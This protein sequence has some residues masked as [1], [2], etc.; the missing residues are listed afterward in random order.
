MVLLLAMVLSSCD[1]RQDDE[2]KSPSAP[3][4]PAASTSPAAESTP[5]LASQAAKPTGKLPAD[6]SCVTAQCHADLALAPQ[7]HGPVAAAILAWN[8]ATLRGT[9]ESS[10]TFSGRSQIAASSGQS[11]VTSESEVTSAP[12]AGG[13]SVCHQDD[14]GGHV[15]PLKRQGNA[16]C[17][18]CHTVT[19]RHEF[20]HAAVADPGC[21]ACH[22][23]HTSKAKFLLTADSVADVCLKCHTMADGLH[24][25]GPVA[26]GE[27]TN[28][29]LPHEA[30]VPR[31]LRG[32]QVPDHCFTCHREMQDQLTRATQKHEPAV[33]NCLACHTP[34]A[35]DEP[36]QLK[37]AVAPLCFSCHPAMGDKI[38][39]A[40]VP[41]AAVSTAEKCANCHDPHA[42]DQSF[43]LRDRT[44]RLCLTC[45]NQSLPTADG[46]L[47][48]DM[49]AKLVNRKFMHGPVAAGQCSPCHDVHG[50][51]YSRLL[52][53][54]FPQSFYAPFDIQEYALCFSCHSAAVVQE[55][56][57]TSLTNFRAGQRNL[58]YVHVHQQKK[59]R[60]CKTCHEIH[61]SDLPNHMADAVP[62]EGTQW[63]MPIQYQPSPDGG[64]CA[65]G[66]HEPKSY[67]RHS[68]DNAA[69][70]SSG[71]T[72]G[73]DTSGGDTSGGGASGGD[74]SGGNASG[75]GT[76]GGKEGTP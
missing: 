4:S 54:N 51:A 62:F 48:P 25:H 15:F 17:Q 47:V 9:P 1:R 44:D 42:A 18:F 37:Q 63:S 67:N 40:A 3:P 29:H 36:H 76:S 19:G 12:S 35:S 65:P 71:D 31:L 24:R 70:T 57:T 20:M 73:G 43:L 52:T 75:G 26:A 38:S 13:C 22:Q 56:I 49:T 45:H 21:L 30:D 53:K 6:A 41:H 55:P 34:H 28:C 32:G 16:L 74:T 69:E 10:S 7:I 50:A 2:A 27:C 23:P 11:V 5:P 39:A 58:H 8:T 66:C 60:T 33:K 68:A 14:Q 72:S 46:R 61:S 64:S 59:G